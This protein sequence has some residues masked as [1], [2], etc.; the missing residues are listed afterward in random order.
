MTRQKFGELEAQAKRLGLL[1]DRHN[2]RYS[3]GKSGTYH[4]DSK[5]FN[6]LEALEAYLDGYETAT[7]AMQRA[8][9]PAFE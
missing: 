2:G 9:K 6:T 8:P 4:V 5:R 1:L 3:V 7:E